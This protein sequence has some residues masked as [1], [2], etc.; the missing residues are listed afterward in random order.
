MKCFSCARR[1][2]FVLGWCLHKHS[3]SDWDERKAKLPRSPRTRSSIDDRAQSGQPAC[4]L[5]NALLKS[6]SAR[7]NFSREAGHV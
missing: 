6:Q 2:Q 1:E 5:Q 3:G 4:A 7:L